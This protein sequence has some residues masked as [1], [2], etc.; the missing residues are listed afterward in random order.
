MGKEKNE[1]KKERKKERKKKEKKKELRRGNIKPSGAEEALFVLESD[2]L[3]Y[4]DSIVV[5]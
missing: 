1:C 4:I 5:E 2:A 3:E